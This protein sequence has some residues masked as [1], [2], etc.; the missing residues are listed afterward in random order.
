MPIIKRIALVL[1][2]LVNTACTTTFSEKPARTAVSSQPKVIDL[3]QAKPLQQMLPELLSQQ[4][5]LVGESHTRYGDHVN[6]LTVIKTLHRS[7]PDMGIGIEYV[8]SPYQSVLDEYVAGR[9]NDA[10]ML[11][12]TQWYQRWGYDFRLYRDIF[13]YARHHNI[14]LFALNA[15]QELTRK[16]SKH[17]IGGLAAHDR[18]YLPEKITRSKPYRERLTRVFRQHSTNGSTKSKSNNKRLSRF[19]DVQLGWDES[20]AANA[21]KPIR[22]GKVRHLVLLAGAGHVVHQAIPVRLEKYGLKSM[23][24]VSDLPEQL[25]QADLLIPSADLALPQAGKMG[26]FLTKAVNGVRVTGVT[27]PHAAGLKK[28]DIILAL[29]GIRTRTPEDIKIQLLDKKPGDM[30]SIKIQ[31]NTGNKHRNTSHTQLKVLQKRLKL[32]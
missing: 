17:G 19:I 23:S 12:K 25:A 8:Q 20:M 9:I 18:A 11:K 16:I 4:V 2:L 1:L 13:H 6:Q 27:K 15:P 5:V 29:N 28:G 24:I 7:W 32:R 14:P 31:R 21:A 22:S 10:Q 3:R 30:V 26:V